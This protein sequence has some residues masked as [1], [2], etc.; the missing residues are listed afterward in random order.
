MLVGLDGIDCYYLLLRIFRS[1]RLILIDELF[2][3]HK[4]RRNY[5]PPFVFASLPSRW[6]PGRAI[7]VLCEH[8]PGVDFA[9]VFSR[10]LDKDSPSTSMCDR[11][12]Q[13]PSG[14][15]SPVRLPDHQR[16]DAGDDVDG[17]GQSPAFK[18]E[19]PGPETELLART[20][21]NCK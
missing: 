12:G 16:S 6:G 18:S 15:Q 21:S 7:A 11:G 1:M 8:D 5:W 19:T 14:G 3:N 13:S 10:I 17:G 4:L 9:T 20:L 2:A